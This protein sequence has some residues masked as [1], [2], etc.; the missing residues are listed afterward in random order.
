MYFTQDKYQF[1]IRLNTRIK[2]IYIERK[3]GNSY[4]LCIPTQM[5]DSELSAYIKLHAAK[6]IET[7]EKHHNKSPDIDIYLY[8]KR[9]SY[10]FKPN[11]SFS[12]KKDNVIYSTNSAKSTLNIKKIKQEILLSDI[13]N[14]IGQWEEKLNCII[15]DIYLKNYKTK[16]FHICRKHKAIGFS[17]RLSDYHYSYMEFMIAKAVFEYLVLT[18]E[19][20]DELMQ[21]FVTDWKR[22]TKV[23]E[24]E[25]HSRNHTNN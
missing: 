22:N 8:T 16:S 1:E 19:K 13:K 2:A 15:E 12:Y 23:F 4:I 24:H 17:Y 21:E 18:Q 5:T 3:S 25:R 20:Q 14:L 6:L 9:F 7:F 10:K 11:L